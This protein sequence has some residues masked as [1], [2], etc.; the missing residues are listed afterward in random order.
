[1]HQG[2]KDLKESKELEARDRNKVL[3]IKTSLRLGRDIMFY[4]SISTNEV[5]IQLYYISR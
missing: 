3:P 2:M 5:I 1:M 4:L